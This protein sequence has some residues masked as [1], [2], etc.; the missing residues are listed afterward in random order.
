[1]ADWEDA[2]KASSG[3]EDAPKADSKLATGDKGV[4]HAFSREVV[5]KAPA[6]AA[7]Y[8][9]FGAGMAAASPYTVPLM[10]AGGPLG[11]AGGAVATVLA[12]VAGAAVMS[13]GVQSTFD[14][15]H[16]LVAPNDFASRQ[17]EKQ[18]HPEATKWGGIAAN[19]AGLSPKTAAPVAGEILSNRIAQRATSGALMGGMS[20]AE[21][22][23]DKG[24]ID[25]AEVGEQAAIGAAMPGLNVVGKKLTQVGETL[26]KPLTKLVSKMVVPE[27][28]KP[29]SNYSE[30]KIKEDETI[31][32]VLARKREREK[33]HLSETAFREKETGEIIKSGPKHDEDLKTDVRLEQ[34]FVNSSGEFLN[35]SEAD[36]RARKTGQIPEDH[37]L[38]NP[39]GEEPGLHS[40]DLRAVGDEKF[41]IAREWKAGDPLAVT[42]KHGF[43]HINEKAAEEDFHKGF[44]Y[45]FNPDT[46]TGIQKAKVFEKLEITQE[47]FSKLVDTP[48]KYKAFLK[49]HEESHVTNKDRQEYPRDEEGKADLEH[50]KAIEIETRATKDALD[51]IKEPTKLE[52]AVVDPEKIPE[53]V[54]DDI[55]KEDQE[56]PTARSAVQVIKDAIRNI[57]AD[58]RRAGIWKASIDKLVPNEGIRSRITRALEA[59]K[60]Y[61]KIHTDEEKRLAIHGETLE[62]FHARQAADRSVKYQNE[63]MMGSLRGLRKK[64]AKEPDEIRRLEL[65]DKADRLERVIK[66]WESLGSEEHALP[67]LKAI[68]ERFKAIGEAA[69]KEGVLDGLLENYVTHV[70]DFSKSKLNAAEQKALLDKI[71]GEI[72]EGKF[73]RDFSQHRTYETLRELEKAVEGTGVIVHTDIAKIAEAYE[74]SINTARIVK[75]TIDHLSTTAAPDGRMYMV[76]ADQIAT[77]PG[78]EHFTG[79][80]AKPIAESIIHPDLVDAMGHMYRQSDPSLILRGLGAIS[81]LTKALNTIGSLFHAYSLGTAHAITSPSNFLKEVFSRGEGIRKAVEAFKTDENHELIDSFIKEGLLVSTE[82]IKQTIIADT[83]KFADSLLSKFGPKIKLFEHATDPLDR[84]VLQKLNSFTWDYMHAGQKLNLAMTMFGRMKAKNPEIPDSQLRQE[85]ASHINNTFGGLDWLEVADQTKNKYLRAM[86]MKASNIQGREWGQV[87]LFAPDWTVS[88]LRAFTT[89]LPKELTKPKNWQLKEGVKGVFNPKTQGDLARKYVLHTAIAYLTIL[90]GINMALNNGRPIWENKNPTRID[91]GDGT[92]MQAAKHS[93]EAAEWALDPDKTLGNKLGFIP[94]A[95]TILTTGTAYP[96]PTAP[97]LKDT[98]ILGRVKAIGVT[99]LPFQ[100]GSAVQAPKGDEL[101]RALASTVGLPIYGRT[102]PAHTPV[103]VK[104]QQR[105]ARTKVRDEN[106]RKKARGELPS[107][108]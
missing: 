13:G 37:K 104:E 45:I 62:E 73:T 105:Q 10:A 92:S 95:V 20:A 88:T 11:V 82:D 72:K 36:K 90:N 97:K 85:I 12:G 83:G 34:G 53:A 8:A 23:A 74:K 51:A 41:K 16:K 70:L 108:Y 59:E 61:D 30:T 102:D 60:P 2:P 84:H 3:W 6:S 81:H 4:V 94:K 32:E 65:Q 76:P 87:L 106:K 39:P 33:E 57:R 75:K 26:A 78:Y 103:A 40:G 7:G 93:M 107:K 44:P 89:A 58:I 86:A 99:A 14:M 42:D 91:L 77:H 101:K 54:A 31:P 9:G 5:E 18:Q 100:A 19:V 71:F 38:E 49:A 22:F 64:A 52:E 21:Q 50:P 69:K 56:H 17:Q 68:Q 47:E 24:K 27:E 67:V 43:I 46:P 1:M 96:S 25:P 55:K 98:S 28:K 63:G 66:H 79:K 35:R 48:E 80:G 15:L 29:P